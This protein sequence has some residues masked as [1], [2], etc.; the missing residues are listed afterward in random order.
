LRASANRAQWGFLG[1]VHEFSLDDFEKR[2]NA[3]WDNARIQ[4]E[5]LLKDREP[6]ARG[7]YLLSECMK[8]DQPLQGSS[9]PHDF[10]EGC[11][12]ALAEDLKVGW[13]PDYKTIA[14]EWD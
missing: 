5:I 10:A 7:Q 13:H 4:T 6:A 9:A 11:Y 8:F 2:L 14:K 3:Y 1:L 12:H